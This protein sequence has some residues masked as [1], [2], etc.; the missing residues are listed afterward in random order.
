MEKNG[1]QVNGAG[2]SSHSE[3]MKELAQLRVRLAEIASILRRAHGSES[4]ETRLTED[5]SA[6]VQR[7]EAQLC[8]CPSAHFE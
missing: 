6:S 5:V 3:L 2:T 1:I 4:I 7:L 8:G